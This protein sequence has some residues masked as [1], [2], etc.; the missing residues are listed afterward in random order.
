MDDR[1]SA[2]VCNNLGP[3]ILKI[4]I[5][6]HVVENLNYHAANVRRD[7]TELKVRDWSA[8]LAGNHQL[9][10]RITDLILRDYVSQAFLLMAARMFIEK[11]ANPFINVRGG[12]DDLR[13]S[14]QIAIQEV[15]KLQ[16]KRCGSTK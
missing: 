10:V 8:H 5:S 1:L 15:C 2:A 4:K 7:V 12:P 16:Y 9:E 11:A 3:L 14:L 6:T 13:R